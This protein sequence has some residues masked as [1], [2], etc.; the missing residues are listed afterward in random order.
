MFYNQQASGEELLSRETQRLAGETQQ[1]G[2]ETSR[3]GSE[4]GAEIADSG[5][6]IGSAITAAGDAAVKYADHQQISQGAPAFANLMAKA[7]NDW[8]DRVKN[9][10][11][12]DPTLAP[13]FMDSLNEQLDEFKDKGF[14]TEGGQAWAEAHVDALRQHMAEK[15]QADMSTLAGQAAVVNQQQTI[16]SLSSTVRADPTS[17]DF[18]IAA[19]KSSTEGMISSSPTLNGVQ[20][21]S[22]RSEI[23]QKGTVSIVKSAALGY[24]EKTGQ[25]P[26]WATDPKYAPYI[27]GAELKQ[28]AQ[29]ARYYQ[30]LGQSEDRAARADRDYQAKNDFNTKVNGLEAATMPKNIGD[31]P[32]LPQD[33]WSQ[34]KDLATHPGAALEPGR[35]KTMVENGET[36]TARLNKPEP[37]APVSHATTAGLLTQMHGG[38]M[39]TNEPIYKAYGDGKL[40]DADFN[41]LNKE[42]KEDRTPEGAGLERDRSSFFKQYAG[43]ISGGTYDPVNGSPKLYAA[44]MGARHVESYLRTKGLD[45]H[46]AYDPASEY[47]VGKQDRIAKW[48]GSMQTDLEV[49]AAQPGTMAQQPEATEKNAAIPAETPKNLMGIASLSYSKTRGLYRDDTTNKLYRPD[50]T[51]VK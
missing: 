44:E 14:Y 23:L 30:R 17:L 40:S 1:L 37:L 26:P 28:L 34:L 4:K 7:T 47:F 15:T 21:G 51:E 12:N 46:L 13:K 10:N 42:F 41:F 11:P 48:A 33:Y 6:R 43:A 35:L 39:T 31:K 16:N 24:V 8:N 2:S 27:D 38:S 50:G 25:I 3:L 32:Q 22:I 29:A 9:A 5:R 49:K 36:I 19:L 45:P 18:S 20:A